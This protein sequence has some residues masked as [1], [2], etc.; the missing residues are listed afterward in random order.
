M[1]K[2]YLNIIYVKKK[3]KHIVRVV[4]KLIN[5]SDQIVMRWKINKH[6]RESRSRS[7]DE[8]T[9]FLSFYFSFDAV[10]RKKNADDEERIYNYLNGLKI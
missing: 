5:Y 6:P 7:I 4:F 3:W 2:K 9:S 1:R 10:E 8:W